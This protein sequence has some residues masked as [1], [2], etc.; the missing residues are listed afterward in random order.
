LGGQVDIGIIESRGC[1]CI[2]DFFEASDKHAEISHGEEDER[3]NQYFEI[4]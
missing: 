3:K 4:V 1:D 2:Q